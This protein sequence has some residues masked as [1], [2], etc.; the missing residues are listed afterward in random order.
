LDLTGIF[1]HGKIPTLKVSLI[2]LFRAHMWQKIHENVVMDSIQ[3][4]DTNKPDLQLD[5]VTK[6]DIHP[7]KSYKMNAST[8]DIV[9]ISGH[10]NILFILENWSKNTCITQYG[11]RTI[12]EPTIVFIDTRIISLWVVSSEVV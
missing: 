12:P 11:H 8:A 10:P 1:L 2:Q 4:S 9:L 5:T 3:F 7:R 6:Q